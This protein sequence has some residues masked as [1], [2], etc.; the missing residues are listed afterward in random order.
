M[1]YL[2]WAAAALLLQAQPGLD[3][4]EI[5]RKSIEL[6]HVNWVRM[7]DYTWS[8]SETT[9]HLNSSGEA[10]STESETWETVILF[11]RPYRKPIA[12]NGQPLSAE[13]QRKEQEKIDRATA[14]WDHESSEERDRHLADYEK[15]R[16]K[17]REFL[18]EIPGAFDFK[19]IGE[20]QID[21]RATW[22]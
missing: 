14:K 8:A 13:Q 10:T 12:R 6:D 21:G 2:L 11:G 18:R 5:V 9:R 3:P 4:R 1:R 22:A 16:E 15:E 17:D 20:E 7:K 19:L